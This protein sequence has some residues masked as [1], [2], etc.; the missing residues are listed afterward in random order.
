VTT[1]LLVK[2]K[3]KSV[4]K[5]VFGRLEHKANFP[6]A[7][8]FIFRC[9]N[10]FWNI[11]ISFPIAFKNAFCKFLAGENF[12]MNGESRSL[13]IFTFLT[14]LTRAAFFTPSQIMATKKMV[15]K[16][17]TWKLVDYELNSFNISHLLK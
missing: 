16:N 17:S 11:K 14:P 4:G 15:A 5:T 3:D 10:L 12:N 8:I 6:V 13:R 9:R 7:Q 1:D 2:Y